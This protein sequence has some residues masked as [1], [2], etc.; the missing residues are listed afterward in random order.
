MKQKLVLA[1]ANQIIRKALAPVS[2]TMA[3]AAIKACVSHEGLQLPY[4]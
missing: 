2:A 3:G 4:K 1:P